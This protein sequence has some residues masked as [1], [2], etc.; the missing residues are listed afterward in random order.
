RVVV[1]GPVVNA[2]L[3]MIATS[4]AKKPAVVTIS[5]VASSIARSFRKTAMAPRMA[6]AAAV[7]GTRIGA[8]VGCG[9][10]GRV[11]RMA[12][13]GRNTRSVVSG[14]GPD[15][16]RATTRRRARMEKSGEGDDQDREC[17]F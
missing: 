15:Q 9:G 11:V 1:C 6:A 2:T 17:R 14:R 4:A 7:T 8:N 5:R 13:G 3:A 16:P 10:G 12:K